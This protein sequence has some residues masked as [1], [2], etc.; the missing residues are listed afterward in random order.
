M[1]ED[2]LADP[3][4]RRQSK[5]GNNSEFLC[6]RGD[7]EVI[8]TMADQV[9]RREKQRRRELLQWREEWHGVLSLDPAEALENL[10]SGPVSSASADRESR[11][12]NRAAMQAAREASTLIGAQVSRH[13]HLLVLEYPV[14]SLRSE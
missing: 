8:R 14:P 3:Y 10:P 11:L 7:L 4:A 9:H 13:L 6:C 2:K 12:A 5:K 1:Q